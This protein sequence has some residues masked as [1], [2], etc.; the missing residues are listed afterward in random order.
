V[1]VTDDRLVLRVDSG[2]G[3]RGSAV[4]G[5]GLGLLTMRERAESLGGRFAAGWAD[6]TRS[7]WSVAAELPVA[8]PVEP[9]VEV[10]R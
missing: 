6:G 1:D 4:P 2:D 8:V 5:A 9:P 10:A 7:R 3:R